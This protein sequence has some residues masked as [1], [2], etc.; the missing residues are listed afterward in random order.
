MNFREATESLCAGVSHEELAKALGVSI[1]TIRQA[2]L[3]EGANA[4]RAPPVSWRQAVVR[5]AE[6]RIIEYERLISALA[7]EAGQTAERR[8]RR[9]VNPDSYRRAKNGGSSAI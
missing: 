8:S 3:R 2:R 7:A 4:R 5:L 1:A 6:C 9:S